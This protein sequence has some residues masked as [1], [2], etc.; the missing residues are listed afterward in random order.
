MFVMITIPII[1]AISYYM[2]NKYY[3]NIDVNDDIEALDPREN[4]IDI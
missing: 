2:Y 3:N 4:Y 1:S